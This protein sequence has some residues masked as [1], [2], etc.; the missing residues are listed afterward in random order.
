MAKS[1]KFR[2]GDILK[3]KLK[4]DWVERVYGNVHMYLNAME[5]LVKLSL[6]G[7]ERAKKSGK[8]KERRVM[9]GRRER[10]KEARKMEVRL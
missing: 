9:L 4:G 8:K 5:G 6:G 2:K 7:L 3:R 10:R 1:K